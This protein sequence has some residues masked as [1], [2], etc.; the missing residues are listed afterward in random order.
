MKLNI[1]VE[2]RVKAGAAFLDEKLA[3][4]C[5]NWR[6]RINPDHV[7]IASTSNCMLC[8][9]YIEGGYW[10]DDDGDESVFALAQ[11]Q[12][13]I[14]D[15]AELYRKGFTPIPP[16]DPDEPFAVIPTNEYYDAVDEINEAWA[17][18]LHFREEK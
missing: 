6:E 18:Q 3:Q 9:A 5:P 8:H 10:C 2:E 17:A 1:P 14:E 13:D 12:F 7:N 15:H 4:T 11:E 16:D